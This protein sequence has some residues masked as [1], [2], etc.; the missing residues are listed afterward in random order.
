[1]QEFIGRHQPDVLARAITTLE[2]CSDEDVAGQAHRLAGTLGTYQLDDAQRTCRDLEA[3]AKTGDSS[4][5]SASRRT[6]LD[7]LR[8]IAAELAAG[9]GEEAHT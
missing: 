7:M 1:M 6:T 3:V 9:R 2:S 5:M 4:R 8:I